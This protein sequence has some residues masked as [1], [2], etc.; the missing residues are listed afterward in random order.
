ML[1]D[2]GAGGLIAAFTLLPLAWKWQLGMAR[3]AVAVLCLAGVAGAFVSAVDFRAIPEPLSVWSLTVLASFGLLAYR[4]YRDPE[5]RVPEERDVVISPADGEVLYVR[6]SRSGELP[7]SSKKGRR[8]TLE[9]LTRTRLQTGDA[10]V[11]GIGL[12]LLDVHVNRAPIGGVVSVQEHHKGSFASLRRLE[13]VFANERATMVIERDGLQIAIVLIASRLVRRIV[14]FI[15]EG[16]Q[17]ACGER[18]GA[19]RLGSQVDLV[20]PAH[21]DLRIR[22]KPG[23]R[24]TAGETRLATLSA[25]AEPPNLH[26][27]TTAR[28]VT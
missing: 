11:I 20:L 15:S 28:S 16:Q 8:Y 1:V 14:S 25:S 2:V 9:E 17:V 4:F 18:I 19:I 24:V 3:V 21:D 5:R 7:V 12:S 27:V 10:V 6:E 22:V 23:D 13:S 26:P